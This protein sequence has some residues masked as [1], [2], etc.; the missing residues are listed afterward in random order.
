MAQDYMTEAN[1]I[2]KQ[3]EPYIKKVVAGMIGAC[4]KSKKY[5]VST[6]PADGV[7]G[8]TEGYGDEIFLPYNLAIESKLTIESACRVQW[9]QND[10]S[11]ARVV[12]TG[13][14]NNVAA[15][16]GVKGSA[17]TNYRYGNVNITAANVGALT[18]ADVVNDLTTGGTD[19][20]LAA[21]QGK[22]LQDTIDGLTLTDIGTSTTGVNAQTLVDQRVE[23]KLLWTNTSPTSSMAAQD[24]SVNS[25]GWTHIMI[26]SRISTTTAN[27]VQEI[28]L[29]KGESG[30]VSATVSG[31][32]AYRDY[33]DV[34]DSVV[35][36]GSG[37]NNSWLYPIE[38]YGMRGV[39]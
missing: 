27:H 7:V 36:L 21:E 12:A 2:A 10:M 29:K 23:M 16:E 37:S 34:T 38:I 31:G 5:V 33:T 3:L 1:K 15:V 9:Y 26:R 28:I 13:A 11:T 39:Q 22:D 17:E 32:A 19:V 20:P 18:P 30:R 4:V 24:I 6:A 35:S 25:T 14:G 8:V